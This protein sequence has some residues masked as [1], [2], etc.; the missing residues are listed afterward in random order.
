M[1]NLNA[2]LYFWN[3][4]TLLQSS[5]SH[6]EWR[7][8]LKCCDR[9]TSKFAAT[10][11]WQTSWCYYGEPDYLS[12]LVARYIIINWIVCILQPLREGRRP[13]AFP[14]TTSDRQ[15]RLCCRKTTRH[16]AKLH[17]PRLG[18]FLETASDCSRS[19]DRSKTDSGTQL[20]QFGC[21]AACL[22]STFFQ[23]CSLD[24]RHSD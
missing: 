2:L 21:G 16:G 13:K 24:A 17:S 3:N 7:L 9:R 23:N 18:A 22:V 19:N 10:L 12:A 8:A 6:R 5:K 11:V 1:D 14:A 20:A 4:T 15:Q